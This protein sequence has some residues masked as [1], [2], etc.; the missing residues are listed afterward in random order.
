MKSFFIVFLAFSC[1]LGTLDRFFFKLNGSFAPKCILPNWSYCPSFPTEEK[2]DLDGVFSQSF[3]YLTK[4]R[5]SFVFLSEDLQWIVKFPR[6]PKGFRLKGGHPLKNPS[7]FRSF[8]ENGSLV[9]QELKQET[10]VVYAHLEPTKGLGKIHLVDQ[11]GEHYH[12]PL[13]LI[14]FFVQRRGE[15]F[16]STLDRESDPRNLIER[17]VTF[18]SSLYEK[19]F[20][21]H[22]PIFDKNFGVIAGSP[23]ILDFGQIELIQEAIERGEYLK[24]MTQSLE[25]KIKRDFPEHYAFYQNLLQ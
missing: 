10:G 15:L 8:L 22:D 17:T 7:S 25:G 12:L 14:P 11:F 4:G 9:A 2:P 13:D 23:A 24:L 6:L 20:I 19:G 5:Q 21:D 1:F 18:F 16:F 3:S